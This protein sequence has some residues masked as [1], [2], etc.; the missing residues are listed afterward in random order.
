MIL[1]AALLV[2]ACWNKPFDYEDFDYC[3][4]YFPYQY[5]VRT[6]SLGNEVLDN[7]LDRNHQ[8][9]I[10][11]CLGGVWVNNDADR[12][13]HFTVDN[14]LVT[15]NLYNKAGNQIKAMPQS[16]YELS[17]N[18]IVT[19]PKGEI[20]G[21]VKVQLKDE[22]FQDPDSYKGIYVIPMQITTAENVD[23]VLRGKTVEGF[24]G[25]P[26]R[27][28]AED[29][30]SAPMDYTLFGVKYVNP[31]HGNWLRRG[32]LVVKNPG[33][34][35]VDE[36]SYHAPDLVLNDVVSLATTSMTSV[37]GNWQI[38]SEAMKLSITADAEGNLTIASQPSAPIA[39]TGTG[40]YVEN[41]EEW[42]GTLEKPRKRDVIYLDYQYDRGDGNICS[43]SDTL[44]FR[45]R[46]TVIETDRP[47][48][49]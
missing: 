28:K 2:C 41:A 18:E 1:S 22:F 5:P 16:Y 29:W 4:V 40:R 47:T 20:N 43:V 17:S 25:E 42:G 24:V 23:T 44:T 3:S 34:L 11:V 32:R 26:D 31:Y 10:G 8:F 37:D 45:D 27:H 33:G 12:I 7:T 39:V 9:N 38:S 15:S 36:V 19:I 48:I 13:V 49:K 35:V 30:E 21:L 14:S 6:L 46:G